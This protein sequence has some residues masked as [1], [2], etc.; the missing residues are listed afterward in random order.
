M[1]DRPRYTAPMPDGLRHQLR[2]GQHPAR[3]V[4]CPHCQAHAHT[5]CRLRK[6]GKHLPKPHAQRIAAWAQLTACCPD[7]E[8]TPTVPCRTPEGHP[9]PNDAV[10]ARRITEAEETNP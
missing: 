5:P 6:S 3:A 8:V 4:P 9:L 10:H 7:C 2:A 1:T